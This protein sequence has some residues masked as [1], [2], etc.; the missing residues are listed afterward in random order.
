MNNGTGRFSQTVIAAGPN[1]PNTMVNGLTT[2]IGRFKTSENG[3]IN[4]SNLPEG[5]YTLQEESAPEGY[6]RDT[7]I[8]NFQITGNGKPTI[9]QL[10]NKPIMGRI[11]LTKL[12]A[13]YNNNTGWDSGTP[14]AG[15]V[16]SVLDKDGVD[17]DRLTT[18]ADGTAISNTL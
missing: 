1:A 7:T 12:S 2:I 8:Y 17:V 3:I 9:I 6:E 18:G 16:Y 15:A 4:I 5:W 11:A 13:N 10:T 14:L